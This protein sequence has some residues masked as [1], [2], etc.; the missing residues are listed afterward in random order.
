MKHF[1][2]CQIIHLFKSLYLSGK[3]KKEQEQKCHPLP[4]LPLDA[5][6]FVKYLF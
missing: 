5:H 4:K 2:R 1:N 6:L 3:Q